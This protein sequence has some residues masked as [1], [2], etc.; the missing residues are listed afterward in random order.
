VTLD[1]AQVRSRLE[2]LATADPGDTPP[3]ARRHTRHHSV[4]APRGDP[5]TAGIAIYQ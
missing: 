5:R 3:R 2:H 1:T 4:L